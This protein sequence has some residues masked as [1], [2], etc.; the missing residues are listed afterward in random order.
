[1][2]F[3][4]LNSSKYMGELLKNYFDNLFQD[5]GRPVAWCS[6]V[7]PVEILRAMGFKVFFPEN[8][9][10]M[11]GSSKTAHEHIPSCAA[12]GYAPE[13]CSYLTSD[14]GSFLDGFCALEKAFGHKELPRPSVIVY[15][16]NQCLDVAEWF[17]W[18]GRHYQV[19]VLGVDSFRQLGVVGE[20]EIAAIVAQL[21]KLSGNLAPIAGKDLDLAALKESVAISKE[22]SIWWQKVLNAAS[23]RPAPL[24]FFDAI[25]QMAP[26]VVMRGTKEGVSYYKTL[27]DELNERV[28]NGV[29]AIDG[30][31]VRLYWDGMPIWPKTRL[32]ADF[33]AERGVNIVASTYANSWVFSALDPEKPFESMAR[34]SLELF[35]D[36]DEEYKSAYISRMVDFFGARGIIFHDCRTCPNNS[37]NRYGLAERM[38]NLKIPTVTI[39]GDMNNSLLFNE[40]QTVTILEAFLENLA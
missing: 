21:K 29:A 30:E 6:S 27:F 1:M 33:F 16:T 28:N 25:T 11:I 8:H 12:K 15:Q 5:D 23:A 7:G 37:N 2:A 4:K 24:T 20:S 31:K 32:L 17:K 19:P 10:A 14:I 9:A 35:I 40:N 26:A 34:A 13:I 36:R 22:G 3:K 39:Q 38:K 18:Y